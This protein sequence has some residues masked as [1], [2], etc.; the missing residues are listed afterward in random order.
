MAKQKYNMK[1]LKQNAQ[2][3]QDSASG[4]SVSRMKLSSG[5]NR[6]LILPPYNKKKTKMWKRVMVHQIWKGQ[7]PI[8]TATCA[9]AE[10]GNDCVVC[11][12]GWKL[13]EKYESNKDKKK[14][15]LWKNFMPTND[16]HVNALD[17]K[18]RN[19]TPK[20]LRLPMDAAE[21]LFN[22]V[23]EAD[24]LSDICGL[25]DGRALRIKG[26][27]IDGKK[28]R[29]KIVKFEKEPA[30]VLADGDVDEDEI[31]KALF[32]LDKLQGKVVEKKLIEVLKKLK[33]SLLGKVED[34]DDDDDDDEESD[35]NDSDSDDDD[36][37][38][39]DSDDDDD[40]DDDEESD[41]DDDD[42]DDDEDEDDDDDDDSDSDDD[43]DDDEDEDDESD[44]DDDDDD[45]P[46]VKK[47]KKGKDK[48]KKKKKEKKSKGKKKKKGKR[49]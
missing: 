37:D 26:N 13:K 27:G 22:E 1:A 39:D 12:Y 42:D 32:N 19:K 10:D 8:L 15:D 21:L 45:E 3:E 49:R 5:T 16:V 23:D 11:S 43:D 28:R 17:L 35:N 18:E 48:K 25:E 33:R 24:D 40:D 36:D 6:I 9:R 41:D 30:N 14:Q 47:K 7:K 31:L 44:D 38:D 34:D 46:P 4:G 29:Y 20:V 2:T